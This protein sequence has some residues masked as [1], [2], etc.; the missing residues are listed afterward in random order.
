MRVYSIDPKA[1]HFSGNVDLSISGRDFLFTERIIQD[2]GSQVLDISNG[3]G[4]LLFGE[5]K[6]TLE[7]DSDPEAKAG[8]ELKQNFGNNYGLSILLGRTPLS[9]PSFHGIKTFESIVRSTTNIHDYLCFGIHYDQEKGNR[10]YLREFKSGECISSKEENVDPKNILTIEIYKTDCRVHFGYNEKIS[11]S[12]NL[13]QDLET[14]KVSLFMFGSGSGVSRKTSIEVQ[15]ITIKPIVSINSYP[16]VELQ[17]SENEIRGK[18]I[19]CEIGR[20]TISLFDG[21][22]SLKTELFFQFLE[23]TGA[24]T[25]IKT[26]DNVQAIFA[27]HVSPAR[28][29]LFSSLSGF[30]WDQDYL[31]P[32]K[33]QN[34][35]LYI[36]TLWDPKTGN[37]PRSFFQ[38]GI[39]FGD[40]LKL[41][42]IKRS[43]VEDN[44]T[45]LPE[46]FHGTY[47]VENV[48]YFLYSAESIVEVLGETKT[49]DG[50]SFLP[51]TFLPKPGIPIT[52]RSYSLDKE[53]K[54]VVVL[55]EAKKKASFS[56]RIINGTE[57]D[58]SSDVQNIDLEKDEFIVTYNPNNS[59]LNWKIPVSLTDKDRY[60]FSLPEKPIA[61]FPIRFSRKDI[62]KTEK[63]FAPKY[64]EATPEDRYGEGLEH[65]GDYSV[66]VKEG[67]VEVLLPFSSMDIGSLSYE[68]DY[69]AVVVFNKNYTLD[70]GTTIERPTYRDLK[71]LD[72]IGI[73][74]GKESQTFSIE[75]FPIIDET[76]VYRLDQKNFKLFI[77]DDFRNSFDTE[78]IRVRD[79]SQSMPDS[80][81][82]TVNSERGVVSFGNGKNGKIPTKHLKVLVAYKPT[83]KLQ[84][85][86][87]SSRDTW[88]DPLLDLNLGKSGLESGFLSLTR[89]KQTLSA[90]AIEFVKKEI[91][92]FDSVELTVRA[93]GEDLGPAG[94]IDVRFEILRGGGIFEEQKLITNP[95]GEASAV[96]LPSSKIE[97]MAMRI[98]LFKPSNK[99]N[100]VSSLREDAFLSIGENGYKVLGLENAVTD[101][102]EDLYLFMILDDG[103]PFLPYDNVLRKGGRLVVMTKEENGQNTLIRPKYVVGTMIGFDEDLPQPYDKNAPK[104]MPNI[105]GFF[106]TSTNEVRVRAYADVDDLRVYSGVAGLQVKYSDL[107]VGQWKLPTPPSDYVSS[108]IG[109][110]TY[111]KIN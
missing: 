91:N 79:F 39:G 78:W 12:S 31:L 63:I 86:P 3:G 9:F 92:A 56:G 64:G 102:P 61:G 33:H 23:G 89:E 37:I 66:N 99:K 67:T 8:L 27:E 109:T 68:Y 110:A 7:I 83:L 6:V 17:V 98:D 32:E 40:Q 95:N 73:S 71:T 24:K 76:T 49:A 62:F 4:S 75:E 20:G 57:L 45:W 22:D 5:D 59:I 47:Y 11:F 53:T 29:D 60:S 15:K 111:I 90:L 52:A 14:T 13:F 106:L 58:A 104:Y 84:Y 72:R 81:H 93:E 82:Y 10:I 18:T 44:E 30:I 51:L 54:R 80:K 28:E 108:Q 16:L 38:S 55:R 96:Y 88:T 26:I 103:D 46:I 65:P 35:N 36:P 87:V 105:R 43:I 97:D 25:L 74:S 69:P 77:Y 42:R 19:P 2:L 85:E 41:K 21:T 94:N 48:P 70:R 50:L 1:A 100:T 101:K 34:K 107:Q